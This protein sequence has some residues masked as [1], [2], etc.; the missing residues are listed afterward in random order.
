MRAV[1]GHQR[2]TRSRA[3]KWPPFG[4]ARRRHVSRTGTSVEWE[5]SAPDRGPGTLP[6]WFRPPS[7]TRERFRC[8]TVC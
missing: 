8:V 7:C 5:G 4:R 6:A 1:P 2:L 3:N